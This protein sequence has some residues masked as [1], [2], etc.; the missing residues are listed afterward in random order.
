VVVRFVGRFI[1]SAR[2]DWL[3][4]ASFIGRFLGQF[5]RFVGSFMDQW[6]SDVGAP[7]AITIVGQAY[8][9]MV[10][11]LVDYYFMVH[12]AHIPPQPQATVVYPCLLSNRSIVGFV[13]LTSI[14]M[15]Y[16]HGEITVEVV[17]R[18]IWVVLVDGMGPPPP[19]TISALYSPHNSQ[20]SRKVLLRHEESPQHNTPHSNPRLLFVSG[21]LLVEN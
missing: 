15:V 18:T 1:K 4:T 6:M 7:S 5:C 21:Q 16:K 19:I 20:R 9:W 12:V 2:A 17:T 13:I 11:T 8:G 14:E 3:V 10:R